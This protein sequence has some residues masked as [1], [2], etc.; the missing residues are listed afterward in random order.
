MP[1]RT[2]PASVYGGSQARTAFPRE[3]V[4]SVRPPFGFR[5]KP[6]RVTLDP[7]SKE[8]SRV[9]QIRINA[10]EVLPHGRLRP[11]SVSSEQRIKHRLMLRQVTMQPF[12]LMAADNIKAIEELLV[13]EI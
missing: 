7:T 2:L 6:Q 13:L 12:S 5:W 3:Q 9:Q 10:F 1:R 11:G 8:E 4:A